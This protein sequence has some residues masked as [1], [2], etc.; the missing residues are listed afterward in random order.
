M[1]SIAFI[2]DDNY[3][4]PTAVAITSIKMH[5]SI[6]TRYRIKV[7]GIDLSSEN[8]A[9]LE[10]LSDFWGEVEVVRSQLS[11]SQKKVV[12]IRERVSHAAL[13]KFQLPSL[14]PDCDKVLYIDSDTLIQGDLSK[15]YRMNIDNYY[16]A[17]VADVITVRGSLKHLRFLDFKP[18]HYFNSG[19]LLLNLKKMRADNIPDKLLDY[20][21]NGKNHFMDQDALN[22]V[23]DGNVKWISPYYNMLNC[24]FEWEKMDFLRNFYATNFPS[25]VVECFREATILHLGDTK[26]PWKYDCGYLTNLY[27]VYYGYSSYQD[28]DM[29]ALLPVYDKSKNMYQE[30][31]SASVSV[32]APQIFSQRVLR[33]KLKRL[34]RNS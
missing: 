17:V 22:V 25:D 16:A 20:R 12:Q 18:S 6:F 31:Q 19:V 26:K 28:L 9:R 14:F 30:T 27:R 7:I 3:A 10:A 5:Q 1:I 34:Q 2:C 33:E 15:L 11:E 29:G 4:M 23:F 24:F 8:C 32:P 13:M 21:L